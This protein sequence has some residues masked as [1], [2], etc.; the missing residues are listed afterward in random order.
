VNVENEGGTSL[1]E[2]PGLRLS[3]VDSGR[4]RSRS[5][6]IVGVAFARRRVS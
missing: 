4:G 3:K 6:L 2:K 5:S 1:Y